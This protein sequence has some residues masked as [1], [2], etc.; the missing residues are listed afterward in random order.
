MA[1]LFFALASVI[2]TVSIAI[3]F[4]IALEQLKNAPG[5]RERA[6]T[7]FF[8]RVAIAEVIPIILLILGFSYLDTVSDMSELVI[9]GFFIILSLMIGPFFIFLQSKVDVPEKSKPAVNTFTFIGLSIITGIPI[10]SLV[11]LLLLLP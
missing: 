11:G 4:K 8:I 2:G 3:V 9:P 5:E 7:Y 1:A 6:Q 10:V